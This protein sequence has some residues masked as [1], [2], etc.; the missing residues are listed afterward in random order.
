MSAVDNGEDDKA[1]FI[2]VS[3]TC[4]GDGRSSMEF[5]HDEGADLDRVS[6]DDAKGFM[7]L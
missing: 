4:C 1:L 6:G 2:G 7:R 3:T 5:F